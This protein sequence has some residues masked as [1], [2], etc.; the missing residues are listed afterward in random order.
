M[1]HLMSSK[2]LLIG[3]GNPGRLDDGL[4]PVCAERIAQLGLDNVTVDADYQLTVEDAADVAEYDIVIFV[5]ASLVGEE[6]FEFKELKPCREISF[7][8][9]SVEPGEVLAL[10]HEMFHAKTRGFMLGI[11]GYEFNEFG[12]WLSAGAQSNLEQAIAFV[13]QSVRDGSIEKMAAEAKES[14]ASRPA[15]VFSITQAD[16]N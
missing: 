3:F 6:A 7:S 12:E 13:E 9:H 16:L 14:D 10:A 4:G 2:I 1:S 8:T 5:D 15:V 11:R